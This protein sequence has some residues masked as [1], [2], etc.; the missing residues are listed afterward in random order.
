M[1]KP[2]VKR[3]RKA[4]GLEPVERVLDELQIAGLPAR[5]L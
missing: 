4:S 3:G 1:G 5:A 2:A